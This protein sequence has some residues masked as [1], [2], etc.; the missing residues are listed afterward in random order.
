M[1]YITLALAMSFCC[2]EAEIVKMKIVDHI[3]SYGYSNFG[4][5]SSSNLVG[6]VKPSN[7]S[8]PIHLKSLVGECYTL[9]IDEY[10]Y[11]LCPFKNVTQHE[12][13]YRWNPYSGILGIW[14]EWKV[15]NNTFYSMIMENGDSCGTTDRQVEVVMLC[16]AAHNLTTVTEP[17]T[18]HYRMTFETPLVC[19]E[20]SMLVYPRLN[21]TLRNEWDEI[22]R[23]YHEKEIT[24]KG[25]KLYL[26]KIF[27]KAGLVKDPPNFYKDDSFQGYE[28]LETCNAE[29]QK[30]LEEVK[31]LRLKNNSK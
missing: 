30:L 20:D 5:D 21:E 13:T 10:K 14:K 3:S 23:Q 24:E 22:E 7:F 2:T 17:Q 29:Y 11:K 8:G 31:A 4:V 28:S 16:G 9:K 26:Q 12:Q 1:G 25:Y 18:C 19:H 27:W 6:K 15:T